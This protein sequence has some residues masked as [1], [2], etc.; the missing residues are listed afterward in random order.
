MTCQR[1]EAAPII[2]GGDLGTA[3]RLFPDAPEPFVDLSTGINPSPYPIPRLPPEVFARLPQTAALNRLCAQAIRVYG[4]PAKA[5]VVAGPG[6]QIILPM[7]AS[8]VPPGRAGILGPTYGEYARAAELAGHT[9]VE[10]GSPEQLG[11]VD[12]AFVANP[13]NPDGQITAREML[14][15]VADRLRARNGLLV[16]D[17]AFMDVAPPNSSVAA[18]VTNGGIIVLRSFGK[19]FGLPGLRV[20]FAIADA[21]IAERLKKQLGPWALAG[22]AIFIAEAALADDAWQTATGL[23]LAAAA[24]RLDELLSR[25]GLQILGGTSLFRLVSTQA[26]NRIFHRLGRKGIVVRHFPERPTCLRFGLPASETEW[27]RLRDE[28]ARAV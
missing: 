6:T 3:R 8:L 22:P 11:N 26:G 12:L 18:E 21:E 10:V 19:F 23:R 1:S 15:A 9:V 13:N 17:E 16:V 7:I 24:E 4:V 27:C 14:V 5:D 25:S 2:H 20:G 28:L